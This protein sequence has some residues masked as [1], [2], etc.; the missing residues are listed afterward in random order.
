MRLRPT[1]Q[2]FRR[3]TEALCEAIRIV[4]AARELVLFV[5]CSGERSR[6]SSRLAFSLTVREM[7]VLAEMV[8]VGACGKPEKGEI[9]RAALGGEAAGL[10]NG[11]SRNTIGPSAAR[12][13]KGWRTLRRQGGC[14]KGSETVCL[15]KS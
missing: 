8:S 11:T 1:L 15:R 6:S 3:S 5:A 7:R 13:N 9:A 10:L 12:R 14:R 2:P 4:G